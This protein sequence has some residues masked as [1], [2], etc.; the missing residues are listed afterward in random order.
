MRLAVLMAAIFLIPAAYTQTLRDLAAA[1]NIHI[2]T[3]VTPSHL[4]EPGFAKTLAREFNQ[5][6]PEN[7]L[8]FG[9][10]HPALDKYDFA[11][12]DALV[13]FAQE[14]QMVVRGHTL[15]WHNQL[16]NWLKTGE[17]TPAEL[18]QILQDH[19][20]KV[21]GHYAGKVYAWDVVNEAFET[22]GALRKYLW[23]SA[24]G[25]GL[26][27]TGF[28]EQAL[29][30]AHAADPKAKLFYNDYSAEGM[31]AKSEAIYRMARDFKERGVPLDG[32]GMQMHFGIKASGDA[33]AGKIE[34]NFKRLT[35][36]GLEVQITELDVKLPVPPTEDMLKA[37]AARYSEIVG[38][39]VRNPHCTAIQ[40]WGFTDRYSWIP[41]Q[42]PGF[43]AALPFDADYQ[44]KPAYGAI[45]EALQGK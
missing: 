4:N 1:R 31:N 34:A 35:E 7:S 43:G 21:V 10:I 22:N 30:W 27:G 6:E 16:P 23:S 32:I 17:H 36:L 28:I 33:T 5:V 20:A 24:P 45:R 40:T 29:R 14:H 19:I 9:P 38:V 26:E 11:P 44:P 8:K 13:T 25:I 41:H 37:Q 12:G 39:C 15:V 2:G 18:K 3:A 42:N